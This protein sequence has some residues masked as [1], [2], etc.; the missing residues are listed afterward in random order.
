MQEKALKKSSDAPFAPPPGTTSSD[1]YK[2][3]PSIMDTMSKTTPSEDK[4]D[5]F[6]GNQAVALG[7]S[8][9]LAVA[10][11]FGTIY[12][13]SG[14]DEKSSRREQVRLAPVWSI[15]RKRTLA[16]G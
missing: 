14:G 8:V 11:L 2:N 4:V 5:V 7:A 9:V 1:P 16:R 15:S 12:T 10:L 3:P 13:G 6:G